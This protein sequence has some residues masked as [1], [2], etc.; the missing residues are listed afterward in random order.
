MR[1]TA[2]LTGDQ[3]LVF[4]LGGQQQNLGIDPDGI[5]QGRC[6]GFSTDPIDP[7]KPVAPGGDH[8]A[9]FYDFQIHRLDYL[10]S[11]Q[12]FSYIDAYDHR[13][14]LGVKRPYLYFSSGRRGN[15]YQ[16]N[17][18]EKFGVKPYRDTP[19]TYYK[20]D[21]FQIICAGDDGEFGPGGLWT[22]A[23][24]SKVYPPGSPGSDDRSNFH[25]RLLGK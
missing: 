8:I 17:H 25:P 23:T 20:P 2:T 1:S 7:M 14:S 4:F 9:P 18:G 16:E 24:A 21:A 11:G 3:V 13:R 10:S 22:P 19:S 5:R 15:H 12:Y 6:L